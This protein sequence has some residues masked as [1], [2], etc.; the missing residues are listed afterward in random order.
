MI[1]GI[2]LG[3]TKSVVGVWQNGGPCVIPDED[4]NQSIPSLVLV[5]PDESI[6]VGTQA[7]K[8]RDRYIGKNITISS[9]KRIIGMKGETGWGWWKTYPQEVSALVLSELRYQAERHLGRNLT[10]AVIAIPSHFEES[11][12]R[13]TKEAAEIAGLRV[14]RLIN[15][16]T[17]AVVA[18]FSN[19]RR[20]GKVLVFDLGGGTL[21]VS[22]VD[23][24]VDGLAGIYEVLC[25]EGDSRL[26][27]DDFDQV[28]VDFILDTVRQKYGEVEELDPV[29]QLILKEACERAKIDLSTT[30]V[31]SIDIPGFLPVGGQ[32]LDLSVS[33]DRSTFEAL[34][35]PLLDRTTELLK[36]A[37]DSA[38][39]RASE[40][41][42]LLLLGGSSRIPKIRETIKR[43]LGVHPFTG[44]NPETC[45]AQGAAILAAVLGGVA[46]LKDLLLLDILPSSY[47]V[48]TTGDVM[49]R[50]IEKNT[51]VPTVRKEVFSTTEDSQAAISIGIYAGEHEFTKDNT[52]LG[53]LELTG[54]PPSPKGIP[55]IE[56]TFDVD[57]DSIVH[58]SA[59]DVGTGN[60][61]NVVATS[62][63]SLN[64][65]QVKLMQKKLDS[66]L[67]KRETRSTVGCLKSCIEEILQRG[68][69]ALNYDEITELRKS[70]AVITSDGRQDNSHG[71]L[72]IAISS[73]QSLYEQAQQKVNCYEKL[74]NEIG[75]LITKVARFTPFLRQF[76]EKKADLL[77]QG[78]MLLQ[79]YLLRRLPSKELSKIL[80]SVRSEYLTAKAIAIKQTVHS[81]DTAQ[82][83]QWAVRLSSM[84]L[85]DSTIA[86]RLTEIRA[87]EQTEAII[88]LVQHDTLSSLTSAEQKVA[89]EFQRGSCLW[90]YFVLVVSAF[91]DL[92]IVTIA[93]GFSGDEEARNLLALALFNGLCS[94]RGVGERKMAAEIMVE[95]LPLHRYFADVV[96]YNCRESDSEVRDLLF[97]YLN[98]HPQTAFER[99][100]ID[101]EPSV[102]TTMCNNNSMLARLAKQPGSELLSIFTQAL[103]DSSPSIR[104]SALEFI[105]RSQQRSYLPYIHRMVCLESEDSVREKIVRLLGTLRDPQNVSCLLK[106]LITS[107]DVDEN[108]IFSSLERNIK[109]VG[110]DLGRLCSLSRTIIR[111][112]HD[113][114]FKDSLFLRRFA[115][116][117]PEM[118]DVVRYLRQVSRNK[119]K[120]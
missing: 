118:A 6:Y 52:R 34:S 78:A 31:T 10:E 72:R 35:K 105:E 104:V 58:V 114:R 8:H 109:L 49:T 91:V 22:I 96:S 80:F 13:A 41:S 119:R 65:S 45:V 12:R 111:Q 66:W 28:I 47:G 68:T 48:G 79:E 112:E 59:R 56:V 51:I 3:T 53:T 15:E 50:M 63:Y 20:G 73:A 117:Y 24:A 75:E 2:D 69:D 26:G 99:F 70:C 23:G 55:Q 87:F 89:Y 7:R 84:S 19:Q 39:V 38:Q 74:V 64:S 27:G 77:S 54:I 115:K 108:L 86:C 30:D 81:L 16:A 92:N 42:A 102:R 33:L 107:R 110:P 46:D 36:K 76:D 37:M 9:V 1:L 60:E 93:K 88:A 98:K 67:F 106:V 95:F 11:Q 32:F 29:R 57:A 62:P 103:E 97:S 113:L 44:V 21:D 101:S 94:E 116:R 85:D 43:E 61:S 18:Y 71:D 25:I 17:A 90:A 120:R 5:T 40:L 14:V 100:F 4:G 82:M 83:K